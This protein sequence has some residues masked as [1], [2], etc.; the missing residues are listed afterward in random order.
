MRNRIVFWA[1]TIATIAIGVTIGATGLGVVYIETLRIGLLGMAGTGL[2][3][4]AVCSFF[5]MRRD[6]QRQ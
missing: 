4:V 3:V 2:G 1:S 5:V 6:K